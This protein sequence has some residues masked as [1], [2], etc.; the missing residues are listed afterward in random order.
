MEIARLRIGYLRVSLGKEE[1]GKTI[2]LG[3]LQN[4]QAALAPD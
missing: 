1:D 3:F 4:P 2:A